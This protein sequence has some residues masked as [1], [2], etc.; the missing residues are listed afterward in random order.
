MKGEKFQL[1]DRLTISSR[2]II[3]CAVLFMLSWTTELNSQ[4]NNPKDSL[5]MLLD[6]AQGSDKFPFIID[7]FDHVFPH[8]LKRS[9]ALTRWKI[10]TN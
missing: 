3:V 4:L 7:L 8:D 5:Q 10:R 1:L 6:E 2:W 9:V